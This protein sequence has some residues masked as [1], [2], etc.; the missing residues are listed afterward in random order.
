MMRLDPNDAR[1]WVSK[2]GPFRYPLEIAKAN[3][4]HSLPDVGGKADVKL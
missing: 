4:T 1:V 2:K 3:A